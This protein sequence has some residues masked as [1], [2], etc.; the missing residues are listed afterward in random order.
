ME[1]SW[2][3]ESHVLGAG[4]HT[5]ELGFDSLYC[6]Q[7]NDPS[8]QWQLTRAHLAAFKVASFTP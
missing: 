3:A 8:A 1:Y 4:S 6:E 2:L 5:I 7:P